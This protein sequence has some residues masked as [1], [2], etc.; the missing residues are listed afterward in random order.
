M[1]KN[2]TKVA[3][4][5]IVMIGFSLSSNAQTV[6]ETAS[7]TAHATIITPITISKV[8]N[9]EFGN[10]VAT[11]TG[12]TVVLSPDNSRT[13]SG[14]QLPVATGTVGAATFTVTGQDGYAYTVTLPSASYSITTGLTPTATETMTLTAFTSDTTNT[15]TGGTQTLNVGATLN[16]VAN[17]T[18]GVYTSETPFDVKVNYN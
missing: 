10:I 6:V 12:G 8:D 16:V 14:V 13:E 2:L 17:Q 7:A 4:L 15:L 3:A 18:P 1:I 11:A 5:A 9:M